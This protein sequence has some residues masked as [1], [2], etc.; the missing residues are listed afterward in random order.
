MDTKQDFN[1]WQNCIDSSR[2]MDVFSEVV[3]KLRKALGS[4]E[5][6]WPQRLAQ[7][8]KLRIGPY[9]LRVSL[10]KGAKRIPLN[11]FSDKT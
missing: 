1:C 9:T 8:V 7:H 11:S 5:P 4:D 3:L 6:D 2:I 10:F